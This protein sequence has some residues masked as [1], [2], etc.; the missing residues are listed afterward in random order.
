MVVRKTQGHTGPLGNNPFTRGPVGGSIKPFTK[1]PGLF[2]ENVVDAL[3]DPDARGRAAIVALLGAA[4][5]A[6]ASGLDF[7]DMLVSGGRPFGINLAQPGS[8]RPDRLARATPIGRAASDIVGHVSAFAGGE[9]MPHDIVGRDA[10]SFLDSD[11]AYLLLGRYPTKVAKR[12]VEFSREGMGQHKGLRPSGEGDPHPALED[13]AD[14]VGVRS[15]RITENRQR[16]AEAGQAVAQS[17]R[18]REDV[19]A[20]ARRLATIAV[21]RGDTDGFADALQT[22]S[23]GQRRAFLR[24][25]GKTRI[26][27]LEQ[28]LPRAERPAF[29]EQFGGD[30]LEQFL[31]GQE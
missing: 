8:L 23:P 5:A 3:N 15:T 22:M 6:R 19:G 18:G 2:L 11:L 26:E 14:L 17:R 28:Q 13:V 31:E 7:E 1:Y 29:R 21:Q 12:A 4:L 24:S 10:D 30:D 20:E 16:A 9:R 25:L 27:R